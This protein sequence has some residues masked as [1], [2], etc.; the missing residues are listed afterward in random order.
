[1]RQIIREILEG[2]FR[3]DNT[4]L[5][6]SCPRI[7]LTLLPD[8]VHEGSFTIYG[9]EGVVT[10]GKALSSDIR[11]ECLTPEF[12]G[13]QDEIYYRI[14]TTGMKVSDTVKG[15]F[16]IESNQ[17]E[18][19]LPFSVTI[20]RKV[21]NSSLGEIRNLFHFINLAKADW[22]EAVRFFYGD[23]FVKILT[24]NDSHYY[25]V[26]KGLSAVYGNEHNVEEFLLQTGKKKAIEY[27]P[28]KTHIEIEIKMDT[29]DPGEEQRCILTIN[30]N[31]WGD[32]SLLI[33]T[34]GDFIRVEQEKVSDD[35]FLGN[36]YHL[37]YYIQKDK[38]H[39]GVNYGCIR[40]RSYERVLTVPVNVTKCADRFPGRHKHHIEKQKIIIKLMKYYQAYRLKKIGVGAWMDET[41]GL[42]ERLKELD[43]GDP[44]T[45]LFQAQL[46][47]AK[48]R[49]HEAR[50]LLENN[51]DRIEELGDEKPEYLCYYLYLS[52]LCSED[53]VYIDS[54]TQEIFSQ[55]KRNRGNWRIVW[56]LLFLEDERVRTPARKWELLEEAFEYGC[57]SPM[58]YLEAWNL[59]CINP[60]IL[61]RLND[62]EINI[63]TYSVKNDA[64]KDEVLL[65]LIYLAQTQ[66]G[67]SE[68]LFKIL[69]G[70]YKKKR[71]ND[72]L[73]A[74]CSL[75]IKGNK[76]GKDYFKW[77]REGVEQNLRITGL[78]EYYV[79]SHPLD[80][81]EPLPNEILM[82]FAYP[83][84]LSHE[85]L[86][87]LYAYVHKRQ[88]EL[89]DIYISYM[90]RIEKFVLKQAAAGAINKDL[91]YLYRNVITQP[92]VTEEIA[93]SLMDMLF[94]HEIVIEDKDIGEWSADEIKNIIVVYP[95]AEKELTYAVNRRG[96]RIPIYDSECS[97]ILEDENRNR[98]ASSVA[99]SVHKLF[100]AQKLAQYAAP[101]VP[102]H[103]GYALNVCFGGKY[104][105]V[106][107]EPNLAQFK[108]LAGSDL[109]DEPNRQKMK[110]SLLKF[111][112]EKD[113]MWELDEYLHEIKP[114][115][116]AFQDRKEAV[117]LFVLRGMYKEAY[118][119]IKD[120]AF[121]SVDAKTL[122]KLC[123]GLLA[124]GTY[125]DDE[126]MTAVLHYVVKRGK[127]NEYILEYLIRNF[128][129]NL[130]DMR[131]IRN[132]AVRYGVDAYELCERIIIQLLY[133]G[134]YIGEAMD[135]FTAYIK[136]GGNDDII[137]AFLSQNS[138]DYVIKEKITDS[139]LVDAIARMRREG[140][141]LH[142]VCR[143]AY[144][145]YYAE[146][147]NELDD[148]SK[149]I[150]QEFLS[151]MMERQIVLPIYKEFQGYLPRLDILQDKSLIEYR[152]MPG[153]RVNI[154]YMILKGSLSNPGFI[155]E[156]MREVFLGIF[157][158]EFVLFFGETLQ[159]YITEE[160][161]GEEKVMLSGSIGKSDIGDGSADGVCEGSRFNML[162]D[163]MIGKTLHDYD[164]VDK[165]LEEYYKKDF[166]TQR[167]F[168]PI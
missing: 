16:Y 167:L 108:F 107:D 100:S 18:Y 24:G 94:L 69:A 13:L 67:Y 63:L 104:A 82:Y 138:Y 133:T 62:F 114:S 83:S 71:Q 80:N 139:A 56:L 4:T 144:I 32:T 11:M 46:L 17:G 22:D 96:F 65:Q 159:Y 125:E 162:N 102:E 7:D 136:G 127:Y 39:N 132:I 55:Y 142:P 36:V 1:M 78:Y 99:F 168:E 10:E 163:I 152:S 33:E 98:Y 153:N 58:L 137:V 135:I 47:M 119:W 156:N 28:E 97:I 164:T 87:Y 48:E 51:R 45:D 93:K 91:A 2:N 60:A 161:D 72:I 151:D 29:E 111:Y 117:R 53:E 41:S 12:A 109:I 3:A 61:L 146:N 20:D 150:L 23:D 15:N 123:S 92:M 88:D 9:E 44:A 77:Y 113:R 70:C 90:P 126:Y 31:G 6:F 68:P 101:F 14:D 73:Q 35:D 25:A 160:V 95:Y 21:I 105:A 8:C 59:L 64:M 57:D 116:I 155:K 79:M 30:R 86:A 115:D 165:L 89:Q 141:S 145:Q 5:N 124:D 140:V 148:D 118:E 38:L 103:A 66:K 128:N 121:Y 122:A 143:L 37:Y 157:V 49:F 54:A 43:H 147:K 112:Y 134:A 75:L 158:K 149:A 76:Y 110:L 154:H 131:D 26:Y 74:I 34:D 130:K 85:Y 50:F 52:T 81:S 19:Y 129:G 42:I 84:D 27:I 166:I 120:G 106:A 40:L